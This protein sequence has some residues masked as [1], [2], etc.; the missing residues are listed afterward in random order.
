MFVQEGK[1]KKGK[2]SANFADN[3]M[4]P[5]GYA[6][7]HSHTL[8]ECLNA[9]GLNSSNFKH[10]QYL[11]V[12]A[13]AL[14]LAGHWC[15]KNRERLKHNNNLS[16]VY[17]LTSSRYEIVKETPSRLKFA[18]KII[19][20]IPLHAVLRLCF[21]TGGFLLPLCR[22]WGIIIRAAQFASLR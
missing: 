8:H 6:L 7:K 1:L 3:R 15:S 11:S 5:H 16:L 14:F 4:P 17:L 2:S 10:F 22:S 21:P 9:R 13:S 18:K 12:N 19:S 20:T